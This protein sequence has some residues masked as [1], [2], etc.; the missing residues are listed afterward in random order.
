M[1]K[2]REGNPWA[3]RALHE[4]AGAGAGVPCGLPNPDSGHSSVCLP[5]VKL[6]PFEASSVTGTITHQRQALRFL[7][8]G[9][10]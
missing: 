1:G 2:R 8:M 7:L 4:V 10:E 9:Q 6:S 5:E 3:Q